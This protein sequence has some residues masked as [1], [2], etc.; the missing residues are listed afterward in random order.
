MSYSNK[1]VVITGSGSGIGRAVAQ[2]MLEAGYNVVLTGRRE[3]LLEETLA[4]VQGNSGQGLCVAGDIS[5]VHDVDRLFD[6]CAERFGRVDVLFNNAGIN[7]PPVDIDALDV[8]VWRR[9]VDTNITGA[10]LCARRAFGDMKHQKPQGGRIINNGSVSAHVPRVK[11]T[12]YTVSKHAITGL[13][14]SLALDG[15]CY[16]I[17]CGQIDIGN[18]STER[19]SRLGKG[20]AQAN[21]SIIAEPLMDVTHVA[22]SVMHM[23]ELPLDANI[24]FM[25]VMATNMPFVGRG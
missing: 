16:G 14:R 22:S 23:V 9:V 7:A 11:T 20:T 15:R 24:L 21:G 4:S 19:A 17:T 2:K 10:F 8:D 5:N 12:A 1:T 3:A 13:T 25:T 6:R 18:A